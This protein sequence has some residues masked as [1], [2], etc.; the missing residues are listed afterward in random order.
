MVMVLRV[1][2][3]HVLVNFVGDGVSVPADAKIAD[4]FDFGASENFAGRIIRGVQNDGFGGRAE[5]SGQ[6][7]RIE[8]PIGRLQ[9]DEARSSPGENR[10]R[11]IIFVEGLEDHHFIAGIDDGHHRGHHRFGRA[12][13]NGDFAFGIDLNSLHAPEF[14]GDGIAEIFGA[15][16]DGVLIDV[17]GD[18]H[19]RR[20][21]DFFRGG[22]IRKALREIYSVVFHREARHLAN[23]RFGELRGFMR[24][25]AARFGGARRR[26][27]HG[28]R[29]LEDFFA[30]GGVAA[31][32]SA[33][34]AEG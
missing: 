7:L 27:A 25:P 31:A 11:A 16:G 14:F 18:G 3:E 30:A 5:R 24:E 21:F 17:R 9:F 32:A 29:F 19:A 22:E 1:V 28:W 13:A 8:R 34:P 20:F 23:Y 33:E 4:G 6:F 10:V 12:A 15:P 2:V 26:G